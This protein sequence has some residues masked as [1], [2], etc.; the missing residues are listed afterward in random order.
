MFVY[1]FCVVLFSLCGGGVRFWVIFLSFV[2]RIQEQCVYTL[3]C[4]IEYSEFSS[5]L[6][7]F[8]V[9]HVF[10]TDFFWSEVQLSFALLHVYSP[11]PSLN[12][13]RFHHPIYIC[14]YFV[15]PLS[16]F[17]PSASTFILNFSVHLNTYKPTKIRGILKKKNL[18]PTCA[19]CIVP[20]Y[21]KHAFAHFMVNIWR[22]FCSL[23][24]HSVEII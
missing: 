7:I 1:S 21:Q 19:I 14:F 10:S 13:Y 9:F 22:F 23:K 8:H 17:P 2:R 3:V 18:L 6:L 12:F 11:F 5:C 24:A 16:L 4:L 20:I 15:P